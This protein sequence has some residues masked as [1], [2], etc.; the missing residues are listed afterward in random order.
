MLVSEA[1]VK[2]RRAYFVQKKPIKAICREL[3]V[4]RK[5]L[6]KIVRSDQQSSATNARRNASQR[7]TCSDL[8][9]TPC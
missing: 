1:I 8:N 2:V 3:M 4:S 7:L 9:L 6:R 5:A